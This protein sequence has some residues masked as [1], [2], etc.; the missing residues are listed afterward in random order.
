MNK[1]WNVLSWQRKTI[2]IYLINSIEKKRNDGRFSCQDNVAKLKYVS[3]NIFFGNN[4]MQ[5]YLWFTLL[6][7]IEKDLLMG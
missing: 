1:K 4:R 7:K 3:T 2:W 6:L 5:G